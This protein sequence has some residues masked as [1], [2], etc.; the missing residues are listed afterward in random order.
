MKHEIWRSDQRGVKIAN[1]LQLHFTFFILGNSVWSNCCI[2]D[3][4][5]LISMYNLMHIIIYDYER[6]FV[7]QKV[8]PLLKLKPYFG[9]YINLL[10]ACWGG[11]AL[12]LSLLAFSLSIAPS[13]HHNSV[14]RTFLCCLLRY[15][16]EI[17]CMNLAWRNHEHVS[18]VIHLLISRFVALDFRWVALC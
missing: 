14:F 16:F 7:F 11:G 8:F 17:W 4:N 2:E 1:S 10:L 3:W 15:W 5:W 13:I 18:D 9:M 12:T 6:D